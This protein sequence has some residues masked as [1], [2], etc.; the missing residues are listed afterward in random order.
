MEVNGVSASV[1][2]GASLASR[3]TVSRVPVAA[4][5]EAT[6]DAVP[7]RPSGTVNRDGDEPQGRALGVFKQELK[8]LLAAKLGFTFSAKNRVTDAV[9]AEL[10]AREVASQTITAA[11]RLVN[12]NPDISRKALSAFRNQ[13]NESA[14]A[15]RRVPN[16]DAG[17][18]DAV[19]E[20][21]K[22]LDKLEASASRNVRSSASVL[23]VDSRIRERS[24]IRIR[25]QEG[26]VVR[27]DLRNVQRLSADD[28][29]VADED[30]AA[31]RTEIDV[32]GRSRLRFTVDGDLNEAE[33]EAVQ[34]VFAQAEEIASDF[35]GGDLAAAFS[36]A[37]N[38]EFDNEQLARVKLRFR[39]REVSRVAYS[40]VVNSFTQAEPAAN[41]ADA[42]DTPKANPVAAP[43]AKAPA[44]RPEPV[45]VKSAGNTEP[46]AAS[47]PTEAPAVPSIED[48]LAAYDFAPL[49]DFLDK[50]AGF[51][52]NVAQGFEKR[53]DDEGVDYQF[54]YSQKM[55]LEI[56]KTVITV[57]APTDAEDAAERAGAVI[58]RVAEADDADD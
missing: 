11:S 18:D 17:L 37:S 21:N 6:D 58:D 34:S 16:G 12:E 28:Y 52:Q 47:S 8:Y 33:L 49:F 24:T 23:S 29:A 45:T 1:F 2:S 41:A 26:D 50:I 35:F 40:E 10:S 20:V 13:V 14:E 15:A 3:S 31:T 43:A 4:P 46:A 42:A 48:Q 32:S 7:P 54:H 55:K 38:F 30:G 9:R 53:D 22:G 25:T 36:A 44:T 19:A 57:S 39:S 5:P 56:L 27:L 51:L